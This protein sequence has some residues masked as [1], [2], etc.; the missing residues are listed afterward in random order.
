M[1]NMTFSDLPEAPRGCWIPVEDLARYRP[2]IEGKRPDTCVLGAFL[3]EQKQLVTPVSFTAVGWLSA[4]DDIADQ[5]PYAVMR[6]A[7]APQPNA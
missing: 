5:R 3:V 4:F 1:D 2:F 6:L 7:G